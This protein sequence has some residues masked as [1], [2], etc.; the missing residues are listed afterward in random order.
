M[1]TNHICP[2]YYYFLNNNPIY[3]FCGFVITKKNKNIRICKN[4]KEEHKLFINNLLYNK[5]TLN[6]KNIIFTIK[7]NININIKFIK[8]SILRYIFIK[9]N[10]SDYNIINNIMKYFI[11]NELSLLKCI[12]EKYI[13]SHIKCIGGFKV[14]GVDKNRKFNGTIFVNNKCSNYIKI[15]K[16]NNFNGDNYNL[17]PSCYEHSNNLL[18]KLFNLNYKLHAIKPKFFKLHFYYNMHFY[19]NNNEFNYNNLY[20]N[21]YYCIVNNIIRHNSYDYSY[22]LYDYDSPDTDDNLD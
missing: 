4:C 11:P 6:I 13:N 20:R 10:L 3:F 7:K 12:N 14:N 2:G 15:K 17:C 16:D 18:W 22:D 21:A 1:N 8:L 5:N 19:K 9:F